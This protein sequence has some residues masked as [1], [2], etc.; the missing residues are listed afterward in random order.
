MVCHKESRQQGASRK[1]SFK[2]RDMYDNRTYLD[3]DSKEGNEDKTYLG[4]VSGLR[5]TEQRTVYHK[6]KSESYSETIAH[7]LG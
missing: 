7:A 1:L 5:L 3:I 2:E 4:P 6:N